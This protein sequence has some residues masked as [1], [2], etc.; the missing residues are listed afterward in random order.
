MRFSLKT[1]CLLVV[2]ISTFAYV[3]SL[4]ANMRS[5]DLALQKLSKMCGIPLST[6]TVEVVR[7]GCL[8]KDQ[9]MTRLNGGFLLR[10]S[11]PE[12]YGLELTYFDHANGQVS[13]ATSFFSEHQIAL[14]VHSEET[15]NQAGQKVRR[16][17]FHLGPTNYV[18]AKTD[19]CSCLTP[20]MPEFE[21]VINNHG[22]LQAVPLENPVIGFFLWDDVGVSF[23]AT[24]D[25]EFSPQG[26]SA[27]CIEKKV[28]CFYVRLI[29]RPVGKEDTPNFTSVH[30][31]GGVEGD[32]LIL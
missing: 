3:L 21:V 18:S 20:F 12:K 29:Q 31:L 7:I 24:S 13:T 22:R 23:D 25:F 28:N 30:F 10:I 6:D 11:S 27:V 8:K 26:I 5:R 15:V 2:T 17:L 14:T 4:L 16:K 32:G 9:D 19:I 1:L